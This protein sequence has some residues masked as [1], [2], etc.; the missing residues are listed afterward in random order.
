MATNN[1]KPKGQA[2]AS[3]DDSGGGV[4][5]STPVLGVVK[6]NIDE[7]RGGRI[8]VYIAAFGAPNPDD[9]SSWTPVSYMSPFF[10]NTTSTSGKESTDY[11]SYETNSVSYG[12]WFSPPDI[13]STVVCLFINGDPN[14]GYYI[15]GVL[16]PELLQM[17]PAIGSSS[18]VT[19]N[20]GEA[21]SYG[22]SS[23]LPVTNLNTNN[24]NITNSSSFLDASKPVHSYAASIFS[25]QGLIRDTIRGPISSSALRESP[26]RVG[27]GVSTPGRPIFQG[28]ATDSSIVQDAVTSSNEK[29]KVISRRSG[30]SIVMDDG[31]I[32]G[33]DQL[34]RIRTALGHQITMSDDGQTLFII[35]S[36]GQS[37]IELGKEGTIDMYSTNSF[38]VRTQGDLNL[39]ADNNI[40]INAMKDLNIAASNIKLT[41]E[42]DFSFKAGGNFTGYTVGKYSLKVHG[43]MSMGSDG[44]GSYASGAEMFINGSKVNLNTGT[45]SATPTEVQSFPLTAHTDSLFDKSKGWAAAPASLLSIVSRAPA[46]APWVNAGQGVAVKVNNNSSSK[47]A[48]DPSPTVAAANV[49][50]GNVPDAAPTAATVATVPTLEAAS[51]ALDNNTTA[52]MVSGVAATAATNAPDVLSAGSAIVTDAAGKATA[53]VGQLAQ[54]AQTMENGGSLKPGS[55]VLVQALTD[56]GAN[57]S[58]ALT[59][60]LFTGKA[61]ADSLPSYVQNL[62]N[63]IATQVTNFQQAQT[64]LTQTGAI[65][66]NEAPGQIAGAVVSASQVGLAATTGFIANAGSSVTGAIGAAKNAV[67][68]IGNAVSQA[69]SLGNFAANLGTNLS[70]GL[71]SI[72]TSLSGLSKVSISGVSGA[73]DAVKGVTGSAF[74][75]IT[76][77][78][79]SFTPN[80]PQNLAQ[81]VEQNKEDQAAAES[82]AAPTP[83]TAATALSSVAGAASSLAG[84][85]LGSIA[86]SVTGALNSAT[87]LL[88][89]ATSGLA[90]NALGSITGSIS[91]TVSSLSSTVSSVS[92]TVSSVTGTVSNISGSSLITGAVSASPASI[93]SGISAL[94]GGA[95]AVSSIVNSTTGAINNVPGLAGL[96]GLI[97]NNA[98]A[99]LNNISNSVTGALSSVANIDSTALLQKQSLTALISSGLPASAAASLQ[100]SLGALSSAS[101]FPIKMP[102]VAQG[103][104]D[105]TDIAS[106]LASV[107]GKN[108][109]TPL[110]N[111]SSD[112]VA[113]TRLSIKEFEAGV[114]S[115]KAE[116]DASSN[117]QQAKTDAAIAAFKDAKNNLPQGDPE[118][119]RLKAAAYDQINAQIDITQA[120]SKKLNDY[121]DKN[122]LFGSLFG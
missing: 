87:N 10:G 33:K 98:T 104:T 46:H 114:A 72:A 60:N 17:I 6:D 92:S 95:A 120:N 73:L 53:V 37:Y 78:F 99:A 22:G 35:H 88:P 47:E 65:T 74:A 62:P 26:S 64:A 112:T 7:T 34:I 89:G 75:A 58:A 8:K 82:A 38:N 118:I 59:S 12:M 23:Q 70:G 19:L 55:A 50:T 3:R 108:S 80:A 14:Y 117:A 15:G 113:S 28:G 115:I 20:D 63:Q 119:D 77:S 85:S 69:M 91:S 94:P 52:A 100:A 9:V 111:F 16:Q 45:T 81:I 25:Q 54:T 107:F 39:H 83:S 66:G 67:A 49:S 56:A 96:G 57:A 21:D 31:T 51:S 32:T 24:S 61:G 79:K 116:N 101:P 40:N 106:Q 41:S 102:V 5:R 30:H 97:N 11:G 44:Q 76:K 90:T 48:S 36:N 43:T 18:N 27:W 93:A 68:G 105:R 4:I 29:L 86:G 109:K 2:K 42:K 103:T 71:G 110:P 13:G 1:F 84:N 122:S 121:I